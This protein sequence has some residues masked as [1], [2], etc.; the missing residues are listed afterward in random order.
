[1]RFDVP[2]PAE[3]FQMVRG[4]TFLST[5]DLMKAYH[6]VPLAPKSRPLTLTMTPLG[7]RQYVK[8]PLGLKDSGVAFQCAIHNT[9]RDCPGVVPYVDDILVYG[10]TKAEHDQNLE[11]ALRCLHAKNFRLQLNKCRFR[12]TEV[13]FLGHVLSGT[14]LR[15][16]P[17]KVEAITGA[18][19]PTNLAQ[20][21]SFLGLVTY[22][23][24]FIDDL[25]TIAEPL[26]AL[27]RKGAAFVWSLE[28]QKAFER[29]KDCISS[30]LKLALYDPNADTYL[31]TGKKEVVIACKSHTLQPAARNYSTLEQEAYAIVWGTEAFEKFLWG[32]PFTIRTDHRALQ[33]LLSTARG[34]TVI[35]IS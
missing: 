26:H 29:I 25:A 15:P 21:S 35:K 3:I 8:L 33:F 18:P 19:A 10:K 4:S 34:T 13:P 22:C 2:T 7:P 14:E 31:N 23:S 12:Q 5:L 24:D 17:S 30:S 11:R 27:Q 9:L 1:M 32:R 6:H 20:L 16:S 28:C